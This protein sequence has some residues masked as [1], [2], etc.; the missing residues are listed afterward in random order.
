M[1]AAKIWW[2]YDPVPSARVASKERFARLFLEKAIERGLLR[3]DAR[4]FLDRLTFLVNVEDLLL[5]PLE[6]HLWRS[7]EPPPQALVELIR[8]H[9]ELLPPELAELVEKGEADLSRYIP[10]YQEAL[11]KEAKAWRNFLAGENDRPP[12]FFSLELPRKALPTWLD[13]AFASPIVE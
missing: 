3:E 1:K 7:Q 4:R 13:L 11:K 8:K 12:G 10:E 9:V 6:Q 5:A 2:F